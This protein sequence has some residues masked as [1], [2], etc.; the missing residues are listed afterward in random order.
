MIGIFLPPVALDVSKIKYAVKLVKAFD[1]PEYVGRAI[2]FVYKENMELI[3]SHIQHIQL[4]VYGFNRFNRSIFLNKYI[5]KAFSIL[6]MPIQPDFELAI[7]KYHIKFGIFP[8]PNKE[9]IRCSI[10]YAA[11][12][13]SLGHRLNPELPETTGDGLWKSREDVS[14]IV[15]K[16]ADL[17]FIDSEIGSDYLKFYYEPKGEIIVI[18]HDVPDELNVAVDEKKQKKI[19]KKFNV[20]KPFLFYP[21]QFWPHKNHIRIFEAIKYLQ[22]KGIDIQLVFTASSQSIRKKYDIEYR[23]KRIAR[24]SSME[25][26]IIITG[27]LNAEEIFTFYKNALAMIMPQLIPEPCIPFIECMGLGCPII[28]SDIPGIKEQINNC[29]VLVNPYIIESIANGIKE[30]YNNESKRKLYIQKGITNYKS[31]LQNIADSFSSIETKINS[32]L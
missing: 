31:S 19:L 15:C 6:N 24:D 20:T 4:D 23:L 29:G 1:K 9:I 13:Q 25:D 11:A 2:A 28:G 14:S 32:Y 7:K 16:N 21:A 8:T 17:I 10:P 27:Y 3:N 22:R 18:P 30:L 12:F 5:K 26:N